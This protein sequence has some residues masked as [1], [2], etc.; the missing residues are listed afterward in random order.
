MSALEVLP[1][2]VLEYLLPSA[3]DP[4]IDHTAGDHHVPG[5]S[6][7]PSSRLN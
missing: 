3:L 7:R 1:V 5:N 6:L 4:K 2:I